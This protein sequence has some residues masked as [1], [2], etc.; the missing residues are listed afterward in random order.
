MPEPTETAAEE[1]TAAEDEVVLSA[2]Q[3]SVPFDTVICSSRVVSLP[4]FT[5]QIKI[6]HLSTPTLIRTGVE[7]RDHDIRSRL[8]SDVV[9]GDVS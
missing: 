2:R 5:K 6:A 8:Y 4:S 3:A 1:E 7:D 9:P